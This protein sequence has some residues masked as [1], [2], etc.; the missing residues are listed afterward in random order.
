[1]Q[2]TFA[3]FGFALSTVFLHFVAAIYHKLKIVASVSLSFHMYHLNRFI[4]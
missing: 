2:V 1:M 3:F 4:F